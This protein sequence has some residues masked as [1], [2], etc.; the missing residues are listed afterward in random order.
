[1]CPHYWNFVFIFFLTPIFVSYLRE[2]FTHVLFNSKQK[3]TFSLRKLHQNGNTPT[4]TMQF[5]TFFLCSLIVRTLSLFSFECFP[6]LLFSS[7]NTID[8]V[9][10]RLNFPWHWKNI[11]PANIFCRIFWNRFRSH[12]N[13]EWRR[14]NPHSFIVKW[15]KR[16]WLSIF[17]VKL[18]RY[19]T[20]KQQWKWRDTKKT[21]EGKCNNGLRAFKIWRFCVYLLIALKLLKNIEISFVQIPC[22]LNPKE[23]EHKIRKT[24]IKLVILSFFF[25]GERNE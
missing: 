20:R 23:R 14:A 21:D 2:I 10:T 13:S 25:M 18:K 17:V 4:I 6:S 12:K 16:F 3:K 9:T 24:H 15:G 7:Q 11:F 5:Y 1:M 19:I 22:R 8:S